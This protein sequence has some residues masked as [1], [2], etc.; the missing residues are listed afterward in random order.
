MAYKNSGAMKFNDA[1]DLVIRAD[2]DGTVESVYNLADDTEY[3]DTMYNPPV[4][5]NAKII[6]HT[7]AARSINRPIVNT[8]GYI[9]SQYLNVPDNTEND[10]SIL[11]CSQIS[12]SSGYKFTLISG[13]VEF[14]GGDPTLAILKSDCELEIVAI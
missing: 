10:Y 1:T 3:I 11:R 7:G 14:V 2:P 12:P 8:S 5:I 6:N 9:V 13:D 4:N